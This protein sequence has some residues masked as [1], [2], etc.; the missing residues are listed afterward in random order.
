[1][2]KLIPV[3]DVYIC[4]ILFQLFCFGWLSHCWRDIH[5]AF[6]WM[7]LHLR[8]IFAITIWLYSL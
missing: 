5:Y 4:C 3:Y 2:K 1:M 8:H 7:V 6:F